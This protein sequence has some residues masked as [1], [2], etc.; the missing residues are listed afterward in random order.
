[1]QQIAK[2]LIS[3]LLS[4]M[5][6]LSLVAVPVSAAGKVHLSNKKITITTG[7]TKKIK[8]K[9]N[10]KKVSW[11]ITKGKSLISLKGKSKSGVTIV[12]KKK[13]GKAAVQAK[14]GK[15]VY[16]CRVTIIK[17][18]SKKKTSKSTAN[19]KKTSVKIIATPKPTASPT[20]TPVPE[21][22]I[23]EVGKQKFEATLYDNKTTKKW[24]KKLPITLKMSELNN[25]EK[26]YYL[27]YSLPVQAGKPGRIQA[28]D[29]KLYGSDCLVLF[30]QTFQSSY[31]YT[32][33]A[34][35]NNINGLQSA[36]G[37]GIVSVTFRL[38]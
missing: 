23:V 33:V 31:A 25:N 18:S 35:I 2:R 28:G 6:F 32:S 36:L 15:K 34:R 21:K 17:K 10:K 19:K 12:A 30:Y 27:S 16:I 7:K 22:L 8:L 26:Y 4:G 20:A 37:K 9:N 24:K 1:M 38:G 3:F 29:I 5:L 11:K 14:I 13:T